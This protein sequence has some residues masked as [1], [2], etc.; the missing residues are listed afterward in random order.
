MSTTLTPPPAAAFVLPPLPTIPPLASNATASQIEVWRLSTQ[1]A[2]EQWRARVNTEAE[3]WRTAWANHNAA[4]HVQ[5]QASNR[6][7]AAETRR[8]MQTAG[9]DV[10]DGILAA[11]TAPRRVGKGEV[12]LAMLEK[13]PIGFITTEGNFVTQVFEAADRMWQ[14]M[15]ADPAINPPAPPAG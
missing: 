3:A 6:A 1:S 7:D 11:I 5:A 14:R 13:V 12:V 9:A 15:Q 2:M 8:M 10:V 4:E